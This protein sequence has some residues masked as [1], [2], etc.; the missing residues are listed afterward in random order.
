M[1]NR[2]MSLISTTVALCLMLLVG[3]AQ[4]ESPKA[5]NTKRGESEKA[6]AGIHLTKEQQTRAG[7]ICAKPEAK[8]SRP[9]IKALGRVLDPAP[10]AALATGMDAAQSALSASNKEFERLKTL[11]ENTSARAR[12]TAEAA[13]ARDRAALAEVQTRLL[14]TWGKAVALQTNLPSLVHS[15]L[16]QEAAL[17]RIDA[18]AG[19]T[20]PAAPSAVWVT[21]LAGDTKRSNAELLGPAP[22]VD[23]QAQGQA[24]L[25]LIRG[26]TWPPGTA[27]VAWLT[28]DGPGRKGFQLPRAAVVQNDSD[29]FVYVQ[30]SD[31]TFER[32][33]V[34][35]GSSERDGVFILSGITADEPVVTTGAQQLL[36]EELKGAGGTE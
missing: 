8:E 16:T 18:F 11:G 13:M 32:R 15:L 1:T 12:E 14:A 6:G 3:C 10:L 19:T 20:L 23:P 21:L 35:I 29:T 26:G 2:F 4:K 25:V 34:V 31:E 5:E 33:R 36:S 30:T 27:V 9:E 24:L 22:N 17:V 7:I 28:G